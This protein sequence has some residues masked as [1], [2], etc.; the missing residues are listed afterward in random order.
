[1]RDLVIIFAILLLVLV[2]L[3]AFGGGIRLREPFE[4]EPVVVD[5]ADQL[6]I[7]PINVKASLPQYEQFE[8]EPVVAADQLVI[9]PKKVEA[10]LPQELP[11]VLPELEG[12]EGSCV[13]A[14][15]M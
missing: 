14:G 12:F 2:L 10:S 15:C 4:E 7:Q 5:V 13:Y 11:V 3:S 1:M 9:H 6:M 8:E